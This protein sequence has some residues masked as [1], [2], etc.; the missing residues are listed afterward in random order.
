[1]QFL[2]LP[3][4]LE[5]HFEQ[6]QPQQ[7]A[8]CWFIEGMERETN[9]QHLLL[10]VPQTEVLLSARRCLVTQLLVLPSH[11]SSYC[12]VVDALV[13]QILSCHPKGQKAATPTACLTRFPINSYIVLASPF[14]SS[15]DCGCVRVCVDLT[16]IFATL[17][18]EIFSGR[19]KRKGYFL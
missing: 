17:C 11:P 5:I 6:Q 19:S 1:M 12:F 3:N 10:V 13:S 14:L 4:V 7:T 16:Q 8:Q 2:V 18:Q 15:T 9:Q